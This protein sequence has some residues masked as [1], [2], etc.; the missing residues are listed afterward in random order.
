MFRLNTLLDHAIAI[1]IG[2]MLVFNIVVFA[3]QLSGAT[4]AVGFA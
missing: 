3:Q 2:T 1:S 4:P